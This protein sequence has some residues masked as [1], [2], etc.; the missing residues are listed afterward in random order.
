MSIRIVLAKDEVTYV[1]EPVAMVVADSR[2]VAEDALA[3]IA[4]DIERVAGGDRS[5]RGA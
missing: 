3:L 4:L 1:G 2:R 5:G